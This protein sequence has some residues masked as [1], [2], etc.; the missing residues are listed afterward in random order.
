MPQYI[1]PPQEWIHI[2]DSTGAI[3]SQEK[4]VLENNWNAYDLE[5]F[6]L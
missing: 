3:T 1:F 6:F 4:Q 5:I 2:R